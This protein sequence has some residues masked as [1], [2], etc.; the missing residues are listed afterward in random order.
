MAIG[1]LMTWKRADLAG[2]LMRLRLA[3]GA[4]LLVALAVVALTSGHAALA[5][6]GI[7]LAAWLLFGTLREFAERIRLFQAPWEVVRNRLAHVPRAALGMSIAH[8]GLAVTI[9]GITVASGWQREAIQTLKPGETIALAGDL[10][11]FE[12]LE[13]VQGPNYTAEQATV[14]ISRD[15]APIATLHPA[16]R[17]YPLHRMTTTDVAIHTNGLSDRYVVLGDP[18]PDGGWILRIYYNPL[19]PW[20]WFG[21]LVMVLGGGLSLSDRRFRIG[22]PVRRAKPAEVELVA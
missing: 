19:V 6:L 14:S 9:A 18:Q 21:A 16:R 8:A 15:G 22:A 1:P 13:P 10:Y 7:G 17:S 5:P 11:R 20:V 3:F 2:V 4:A 12:R